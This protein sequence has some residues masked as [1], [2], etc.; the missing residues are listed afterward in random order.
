MTN[1][2]V[3]S[4]DARDYK[5]GNPKEDLT[6]YLLDIG[7]RQLESYSDSTIHF[8]FNYGDETVDI[9]LNA[10]DIGISENFPDFKYSLSVIENDNQ[11]NPLII[12]GNP[13]QPLKDDYD[14]M[15]MELKMKLK[16]L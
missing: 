5:N 8:F 16:I 6:L 12:N 11:N 2:F 7:I 14:N 13:K 4:Y 9:A 1:W 10:F 3:I 15:V